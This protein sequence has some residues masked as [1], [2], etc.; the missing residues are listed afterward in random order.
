MTPVSR[1][2]QIVH[3]T[4]LD[5]AWHNTPTGRAAADELSRE[6]SRLVLRGAV[7]D[8]PQ[9]WADL[10]LAG[11]KDVENRSW[12]PPSTLPQW[13]R[14][15]RRL[16]PLGSRPGRWTALGTSASRATSAGRRMA[17]GR[18]DGPFPFRLGIHAAAKPD[19][20]DAG[21]RSWRAST[22]RPGKPPTPTWPRRAARVG[23]GHRLPPRR[24]LR[25]VQPE[26]CSRWAQPDVYHWEVRDPQLLDPQLQDLPVPWKGRQGLWGIT[27][28]VT[29]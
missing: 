5:A 27:A 2:R 12:Q 24:R 15:E 23:G 25:G 8:G 29:T 20:S 28:E 19:L 7:A 22:R 10:L 21:T 4:L 3:E 9:P 6:P 13:G 14:C 18:P 1:A 17:G 26:H 16:R 11:V